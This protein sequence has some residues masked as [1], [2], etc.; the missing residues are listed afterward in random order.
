MTRKRQRGE[1]KKNIKQFHN[2][3]FAQ[4]LNPEGNQKKK[5]KNMSTN[6]RKR[7]EISKGETTPEIRKEK[8]KSDPVKTT[9]Q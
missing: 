8:K 2:T 7:R 3:C 1:R 4:A 6:R 9:A 5:K